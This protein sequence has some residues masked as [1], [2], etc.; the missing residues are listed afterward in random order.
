MPSVTPSISVRSKWPRAL[1][2]TL[3]PLLLLGLA[4]AREMPLP[5]LTGRVVDGT[6]LLTSEQRRSLETRL[7][8][9]EETQGAQV[10]VLLVPSTGSETV[11]QFALRVVEKWKLG[12]EKVDDGIL[13][14]IAMEDRTL[15]IEVGYGLEGAVSDAVSK[16]I[17]SEIVTPW[18]QE[19]RYFEGIEAGVNSLIKVIEGE[20]LPPPTAKRGDEGDGS[21]FAILFLLIAVAVGMVLKGIFGRML[22]GFFTGGL[23]ALFGWLFLG[24]LVVALFFGFFAFLFVIA[25]NLGGRFGRGGIGRHSGWGG[26][27][28]GGGRRGGGFGGGFGGGGGGFGGG[29]ASGRW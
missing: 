10:A 15:R 14:L 28:F 21:G 26:G 5:E 13:F 8:A 7:Q 4:V 12:R 22:G 1:V 18:F 6:G 20:P 25:G 23:V 16:R 17:I 11:E 2:A 29:G 3:F 19:G 27:G 9:L 24:S